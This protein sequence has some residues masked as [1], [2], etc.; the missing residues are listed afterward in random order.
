VDSNGNA[1]LA[2][3]FFRR[4]FELLGSRGSLGFVATNVVADGHTR[5]TGLLPITRDGGQIFYA[6]S[7][8]DW[9]GDAGI[10]VAVVCVAKGMVAVAGA[11]LDGI[12][13]ERIGSDLTA[14]ADR[15]GIRSVEP[16]LED[17]V[18]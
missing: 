4:A 13:T 14:G 8:R 3:Y 5:A 1:D 18:S 11:V 2:A 7:S 10:T 9:G 12:R 16:V 17:W 15:A 6:E